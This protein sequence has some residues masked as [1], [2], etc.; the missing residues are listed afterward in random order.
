[1]SR[2]EDAEDLT[3]LIFSR[4]L[5]GLLSYRGGSVAAWL[6]GIAHNAVANHLR[7]RRPH[8]SLEHSVLPDGDTADDAGD[9][10]VGHV[11]RVEERREL[12]ALIAALPERHRE[13]LALKLA[14]RLSAREI[15]RCWASAKVR[16]AWPCPGSWHICVTPGGTRKRSTDHERKPAS[17]RAHRRLP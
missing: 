7:D 10:V 8:L 15:A 4:A 1:M 12:A 11:L 16:Y 13:M 5:T 6:F 3:S 14:G 9:S 2:P 17:H